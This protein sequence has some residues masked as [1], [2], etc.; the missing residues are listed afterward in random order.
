MD[1]DHEPG[2]TTHE[3]PREQVLDLID[4]NVVDDGVQKNAIHLLADYDRRTIA[5]A[6][7]R[8][9]RAGEI[10]EVDGRLKRTHPNTGDDEDADDENGGAWNPKPL[11]LRE[12]ETPDETSHAARNA[13]ML[14]VAREELD[15]GTHT[16]DGEEPRDVICPSCGEQ[17]FD[18]RGVVYV[19]DTRMYLRGCMN[20]GVEFAVETDQPVIP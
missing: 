15:R 2:R 4:A 11:E 5:R 20:C 14:R 7:D 12:G 17:G 18:G 3:T 9:K 6:V 8:L 19:G 1:P 13:A 16:H 10:Y